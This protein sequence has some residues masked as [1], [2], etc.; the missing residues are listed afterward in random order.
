MAEAEDKEL[1]RERGTLKIAF[2][3]T[4][5]ARKEEMNKSL[6]GIDDSTNSGRE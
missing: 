5:E 1:Q 3:N 4:K 6:E 2:V